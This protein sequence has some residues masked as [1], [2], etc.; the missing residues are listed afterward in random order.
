MFGQFL[1]VLLNTLFQGLMEFTYDFFYSFMFMQFKFIVSIVSLLKY[2]TKVLL[3]S[4]MLIYFLSILDSIQIKKIILKVMTFT[5]I[6]GEE[7]SELAVI[8]SG[9]SKI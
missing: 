5:T 1:L 9:H 2:L 7:V 6:Y 3:C 8:K 4:R